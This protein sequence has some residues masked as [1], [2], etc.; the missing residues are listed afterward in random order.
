MTGEITLRGRVLPIGGLKREAPGGKE[1]RHQDGTCTE[2]E[3]KDVDELSSEITKGLEI[4]PVSQME[5]VLKIALM[6]TRRKK[7]GN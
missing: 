5:E 7:D 3:Q 4:I 6:R 2:G 1:C